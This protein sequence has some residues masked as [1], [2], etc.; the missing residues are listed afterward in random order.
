VLDVP[1]YDFN[2]Q[3]N[4]EFKEPLPLADIDDLTF[5]AVFDNS[6]NNPSN[7]DA[8]EF[9]T[10]GDQTWQEMA[11]TFISV[12]RPLAKQETK[13]KLVNEQERKDEME[14]SKQQAYAFADRYI[15]RFDQNGDEV[16]TSFELPDSVRMFSFWSFDHDRDSR[17]SRDEIAEERYRR[18]ERNR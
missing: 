5:V 7:P 1:A 14:A 15:Q 12:A 18:L 4:Y 11:V 8:S 3:H 2:W 9:V 10:W 6:E 16:L 17:I 13:P